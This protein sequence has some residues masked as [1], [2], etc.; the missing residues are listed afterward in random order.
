MGAKKIRLKKQARCQKMLHLGHSD[1]VLIY[2]EIM[3]T[4]KYSRSTYT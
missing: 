4:R 1:S 3:N 2:I